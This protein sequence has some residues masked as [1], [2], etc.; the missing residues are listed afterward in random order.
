L[1][2]LTL[3]LHAQDDADLRSQ[4]CHGYSELPQ[5]NVTAEAESFGPYNLV[6]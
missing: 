1:H 5:T 6:D 3:S 2:L 4:H